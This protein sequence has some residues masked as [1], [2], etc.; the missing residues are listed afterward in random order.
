MRLD[1][2]AKANLIS[3]SDIKEMQ[4]KPHIYRMRSGLKDYNGQPIE[5]F[6]TCKLK[7][8]VKGKVHHVNFSVVNE[9]CELLLGDES[10]EELGLVKRVYCIETDPKF[11]VDNI[12]Q[13]FSDVFKGFG[14]LPFTYKIQLK[15]DAQ[16]VVHAPCRV[17]AP[18]REALKQELDRMTNLGV[19]KKVQEPTDWVNYMVVT[20][21]KNGDLQLCMDPK[22]LNENTKREYYQIPTREEMIREM[23]G[24]N[25]FTKLEASQGFW[26]L[27]LEESQWRVHIF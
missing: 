20:K 7:V 5:C 21:K 23:A 10:C 9:K 6:G 8:N 1:T 3:T 16:P 15:E 27:Q 22:D 12:V 18:L 17:P 19:I 26:Q 13:N 24:A 25:Y 2:G 14:T 11:D 4:V